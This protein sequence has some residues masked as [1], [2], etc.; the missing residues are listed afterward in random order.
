VNDATEIW[1]VVHCADCKVFL[2]TWPPGEDLPTFR[3]GTCNLIER[4][5]APLEAKLDQVLSLVTALIP[6]Q[7]NNPEVE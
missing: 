6:K 3:C 7:E 5:V 2:R 4:R 1:Q